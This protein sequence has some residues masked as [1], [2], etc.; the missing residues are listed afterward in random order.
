[1]GSQRK[2][3]PR[4]E[5]EDFLKSAAG[6]KPAELVLKNAAYLDVFTNEFRRGDIAISHGA[7]AGIG[8]YSGVREIDMSGKTIVPGFIDGHLHI[9]STTVVPEVF[10]REALK[11]GTT[12]VLTDPHEIANVMGTE[13]IQYMLEA[14]EG[15]PL[16]IFFMIPS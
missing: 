13:G 7:F 11:R 6:E 9:E 10:A 8:Q 15:L 1:M 12:A 14:S 2:N 16:D 3:M 4:G 5:Y